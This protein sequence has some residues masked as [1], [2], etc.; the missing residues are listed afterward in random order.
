MCP[1]RKP[2]RNCFPYHTTNNRITICATIKFSIFIFSLSPVVDEWMSLKL[3][4]YCTLMCISHHK[5]IQILCVRACN[6]S[7]FV[8]R[9]PCHPNWQS[10]IIHLNLL[11]D[12]EQ[13]IP[14]SIII[15]GWVWVGGAVLVPLEYSNTWI[16]LATAFTLYSGTERHVNATIR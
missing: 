16:A 12:D 13:F 15:Y 6:S 11:S 7:C 5:L 9:V 1:T 2:G 10:F 4:Q 14:F 3:P 8:V